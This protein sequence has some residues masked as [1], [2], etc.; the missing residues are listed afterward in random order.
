MN[1]KIMDVSKGSYVCIKKTD[2]LYTLM[3]KPTRTVVLARCK[4]V[5]ERLCPEF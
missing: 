4:G 3:D 5:N 2:V 1:A